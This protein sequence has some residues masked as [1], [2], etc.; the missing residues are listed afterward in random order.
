MSEKLAIKTDDKWHNGADKVT[1]TL[2]SQRPSDN[3]KKSSWA[4]YSVSKEVT[5]EIVSNPSLAPLILHALGLFFWSEIRRKIKDIP[6][7]SILGVSVPREAF[8]ESLIEDDQQPHLIAAYASLHRSLLMG[9][10][11]VAGEVAKEIFDKE[12]FEPWMYSRKDLAGVLRFLLD[13]KFVAPGLEADA[14]S[15]LAEWDALMSGT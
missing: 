10:T 3:G 6:R 8:A 7:S 2:N 1:R 15:I 13:R 9:E 4:H 12:L 11:G 14:R 5:E